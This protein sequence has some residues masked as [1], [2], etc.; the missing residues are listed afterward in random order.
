MSNI[1]VGGVPYAPDVRKLDAHYG[2]PQIGDRY[3][4][5]DV[6]AI[7]DLPRKSCRFLGI[8][9]AW[10]K[11][12]YKLYNL[13]INC[14]PNQ[15]FVVLDDS[16]RLGHGVS[17]FKQGMRKLHNTHDITRGC[18]DTKLDEQERGRKDHLVRVSRQMIIMERAEARKLPA[19]TVAPIPPPIRPTRTSEPTQ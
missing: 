5:T 15:G 4:Y 14:E 8:T 1:Y 9:R 17:V 16:E 11:N 12:G 6:E 19:P 3:P 10:R 18:D 2:R 7:L 13:V